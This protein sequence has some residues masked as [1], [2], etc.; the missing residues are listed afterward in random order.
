MNQKKKIEVNQKDI[1]CFFYL[2]SVKASRTDQVG[3]DAY[4]HLG[5]WALYKRL[6]GLERLGLIQGQI[7]AKTGHKKVYSITRKAFRKY[8]FKGEVKRKEVK[9]DAIKHDT[10]LVDIRHT[11][12]NLERVN[13]YIP[14]NSLQT[15]PSTYFGEAMI[16]FIRCNSDAVVEVS[17][18]DKSLLFALEYEL[19]FKNEFR[20]QE[21]IKKYYFERS[22][23]CVLYVAESSSDLARIMNIER[24]T[25]DKGRSKFFYTTFEDLVHK[26]KAYFKNW[27]GEVMTLEVSR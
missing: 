10:G 5:K 13:K 7:S 9:S 22:I 2:H 20:Y 8:L 27:K 1:D 6:Q 21:L 23:P 16:P 19:S 11:L 18:N 24:G 14:E 15:W 25:D 12:L 26:R 3:R 17:V 4:P